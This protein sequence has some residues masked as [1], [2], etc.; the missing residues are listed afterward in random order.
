MDIEVWVL[1][2]CDVFDEYRAFASKTI[3]YLATE[4]IYYLLSKTNST[5]GAVW[6]TR[7]FAILNGS[8]IVKLINKNK[9][10]IFIYILF[11]PKQEKD[12]PF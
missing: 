12:T 11:I 10:I 7:I 6:K 5:T 9:Y 1:S 4:Y 2:G 3:K 8:N